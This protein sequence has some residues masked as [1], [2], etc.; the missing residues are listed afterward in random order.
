MLS[1]ATFDQLVVAVLERSAV[2]CKK[3]D[4]CMFG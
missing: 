2:K 4:Q 1:E 3:I